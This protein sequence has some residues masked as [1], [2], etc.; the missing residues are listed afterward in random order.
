L[1]KA[2]QTGSAEELAAL[3]E[4]NGLELNEEQARVL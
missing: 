3:A 2:K 1:Q 4:E